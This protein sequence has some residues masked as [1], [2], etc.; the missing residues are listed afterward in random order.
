MFLKNFSRAFYINKNFR[1]LHLIYLKSKII[2]NIIFN[3]KNITDNV[4]ILIVCAEKDALTLKMCINSVKKNLLHNIKDFYVISPLSNKIKKICN[5]E[6]VKFVNEK[7]ILPKKN[8]KI[9]YVHQ[10]V[11]RSNWLYQQFL[12]YASVITL[13]KCNYKFCINADTILLKNQKFIFN[14]RILFNVS[15][16]YHLPYFKIFTKMFK[17]KTLNVSLTSHHM[18]YDKKVMKQMLKK[19]EVKYSDKWY[20]A[21]INNCNLKINSCHSD[22]ETYGQYFFNTFPERS[23]FDYWWNIVQFNSLKIKFYY[24]F[25]YK[26][27]SF[28][29]WSRN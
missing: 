5:A 18:L 20:K 27:V 23:I 28:H 7:K 14:N 4:D 15:D 11:D 17:K 22:F 2:K 29:S 26:S 19:I 21:I 12:S 3:K 10:G 16:E 1:N 9:D 24:K 8:L 6:R 13:G 25:F